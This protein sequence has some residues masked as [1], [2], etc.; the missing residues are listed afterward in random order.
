MKIKIRWFRK[1]TASDRLLN[2]ES[3]P[4]K[5]IKANIVKNMTTRI[6]QTTEASEEQKE[7]LL[8]LKK[9]L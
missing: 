5:S 4:A 6:I 8:Q 1:E 9:M 7:D 2:Y 3:C